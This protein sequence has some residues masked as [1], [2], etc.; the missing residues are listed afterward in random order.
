MH[1]VRAQTEGAERFI[2]V[3]PAYE[4]LG[5]FCVNFKD[6]IRLDPKKVSVKDKVMYLIDGYGADIV[7]TVCPARQAQVEGIEMLGSKGRISLFG[8]LL[9]D[10]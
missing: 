1:A 3:D 6:I 10:D 7:I 9:K 5:R 4:R 8:G 2:M